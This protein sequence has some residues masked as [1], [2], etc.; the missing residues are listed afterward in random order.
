MIGGI[1]IDTIYLY[2]L[3]GCTVLSILL[4]VFGDIFDFDGPVD[5]MLIVPWLAFTSLFG[6]AFESLFDLNHGLVLFLSGG[7]STIIVFLMNFYILV[8][9]R[10]S[11]ASIAVSEKDLEGRKATVITPIPVK[12]M[13]EIKISSVTGIITRPASFYQPQEVEVKAGSDVLIIEIKNRVCYVVPYQEN[14]L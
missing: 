12:G 2:V 9:L 11:E 7:I 5:P 13:G 1:P 8:P 14:F 10:N 3:I 6:I 4:F